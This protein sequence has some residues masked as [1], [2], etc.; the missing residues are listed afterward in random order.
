MG[1]DLS[2]AWEA[3]VPLIAVGFT[4]GVVLAVIFGAI[5]IG[6]NFAPYIFVG[7]L[8]VWFFGG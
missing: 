3:L 8:L 4:I 1:G 5:K 2:L 6:W 7:A